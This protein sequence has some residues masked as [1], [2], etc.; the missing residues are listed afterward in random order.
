MNEVV[1]KVWAEETEEVKQKVEEHR[2]KVKE[3]PDDDNQDRE[4]RNKNYQEYR[5]D[6]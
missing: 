2:R 4:A 1:Q 3:E 5:F 6:H